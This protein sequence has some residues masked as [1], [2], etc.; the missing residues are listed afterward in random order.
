ME[1]ASLYKQTRAGVKRYLWRLR[2]ALSGMKRANA[3]YLRRL[4][5]RG[6]ERRRAKPPEPF[7]HAPD[8][9]AVHEYF[10]RTGA[11]A[12][13]SPICS[14]RLTGECYVCKETVDFAVNV[15]SGGGAVNWRETLTCP[16]C[17]LINRWRSCIHL[18]EAICKPTQLDRVYLTE[19]LSPVYVE[20]AA[21]YPLLTG[22]EYI[23]QAPPGAIVELHGQS[24]RNE[25]VTRLSFADGSFEA[26]LCFDVLEHVPDYRAALREFCRVLTPAGQLVL[27]V[28]FSFRQETVVRAVMNSQG[29]VEHLLP[30][31][32]HGDPLSADGVL[33]YYDFGMDLL[34]EMK[35]AG[36]NQTFL[37]CYRS[38]RWGYLQENVAYVARRRRR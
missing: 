2:S 20:L 17:G 33:S 10:A 34:D 25:D 1:K 30:P 16:R 6:R 31:S 8:I 26:L 36:F 12:E 15:P 37:I 7:F 22:S 9:G 35:H 3:E 23:A 14:N 28:P 32:Y 19:T 24:V 18:F 21:R 11:A 38:A 5:N 13:S 27:S 29:I 4:R